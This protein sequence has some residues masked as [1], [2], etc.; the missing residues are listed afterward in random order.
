MR[1]LTLAQRSRVLRV[2]RSL[3]GRPYVWG[4]AGP[5][6][7]DCSGYVQFVFRRALGRRLPK[8]TDTQYAVLRH[9]GRHALRPGDLVFVGHRRHHKSH[10]GIYAGH[11]MWWDAPHT[12]SH[13]RK[14]PV[15]GGA[16]AY[17]RVTFRKH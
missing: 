10:V 11:G 15:W 7:F 17:A 16:H 1:D 14:Q 3:R 9:I 4:A 8:Y 5:H 12:G 6:A 2:P 13:V